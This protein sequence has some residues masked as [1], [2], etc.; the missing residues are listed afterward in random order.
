MDAVESSKESNLIRIFEKWSG[1]KVNDF[2]VLP[3]SGSYREYYRLKN[4]QKN[5]IG[6]YNEDKKENVAFVNFTK[7]FYEKGL[8]VPQIYEEDL[9]NNI[10]L[11]EDLGD[12]TLFSHLSKQRKEG[13]FPATLINIYKKVVT[14]LPLFQ[15]SASHDLDYSVCYPRA[16]FDKQSM[17][18]DLNYFKYYFL[19][20]LDNLF[21]SFQHQFFSPFSIHLQK[22]NFHIFINELV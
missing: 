8:K 15:V 13:E 19:N 12:T 9:D 7:H 21:C 18:W 4:H 3:R 5:A 16:G 14:D 1:S 22:C 6:V 20:I 10:Y 17:M 2:F 11:L